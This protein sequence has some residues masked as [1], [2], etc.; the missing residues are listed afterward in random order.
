[1]SWSRSS[2]GRRRSSAPLG[3][4]SVAVSL[5]ELL[6]APR[7]EPRLDAP[8]LVKEVVEVQDLDAPE[9]VSSK[10]VRSTRLGVRFMEERLEPDP[11]W[12]G[13]VKGPLDGHRA[14]ERSSYITGQFWP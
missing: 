5:Q 2:P 6:Q 8:R 11:P 14:A 7:L 9:P 12:K 3:A 4:L 13:F 10:T 1:M